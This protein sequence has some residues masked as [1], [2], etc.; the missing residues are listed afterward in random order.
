MFVAFCFNEPV[1]T[2]FQN[3]PVHGRTFFICE[4]ARAQPLA[5]HGAFSSEVASGSREEN[6]IK[7]KH[8]SS[9]LHAALTAEARHHLV[10][11][12]ILAILNHP[13]DKIRM[14]PQ[15]GY[16]SW[17]RARCCFALGCTPNP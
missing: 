10:E 17:R 13:V 9:D 3:A 16:P 2:S 6:A 15:A 4:A 1:A 5:Q 7:Q 12:D 14:A 11:R 8:G